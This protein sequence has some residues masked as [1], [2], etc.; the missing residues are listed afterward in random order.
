M[1]HRR[2][3][4]KEGKE[5]HMAEALRLLRTNIHFMEPKKKRVILCTSTVPGEGKS[6]VTANYA[7][8]VAISGE[9][10]LLIDCDIRRPRAHSIFNLK[11][12]TGIADILLG[13][14]RTEEVIFKEVEKNLDLL[15]SKHLNN[16]VT[17]LFLGG[18]M[19]NLIENLKKDY[20]LILLD[21]PPL[22]A[23]SDA[24]ILSKYSDGVIFVC[25]YGMITKKELIQ[26]K[27]MLSKA[28]ANLYGIVI[29][30]I[31]ESGYAAGNYGYYS[32]THKYYDEYMSEEN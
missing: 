18:R 12:E 32:Y 7:M 13:K 5:T 30:K 2:I 23:T 11:V 22:L 29:N 27:K 8:S 6:F 1:G 25:G 16:N 19:K 3:F 28:E 15:P 17:E 21:T 9:K 10:V 4:L 26:A 20:D 31:E 14:K 24:A